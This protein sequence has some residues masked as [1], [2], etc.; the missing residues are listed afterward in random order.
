MI[1]AGETSSSLLTG[2]HNRREYLSFLSLGRNR[3]DLINE[4]DS[5]GVL[6]GFLEGFAQV[7][8]ALTGQLGHDL[9]T[10]DEEEE[11]PSL[12]CHC[13]SDEGLS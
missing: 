9:W 2:N 1:E 4:D 5:W 10:V 13:S 6:L 8:L 3:V 12:V 7:A 11:C